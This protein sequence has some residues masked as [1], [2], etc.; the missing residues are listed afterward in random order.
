MPVP[1]RPAAIALAA[2]LAI[3]GCTKSPAV[4]VTNVQAPSFAAMQAAATLPAPTGPMTI[5]AAAQRAVQW[6]PAVR[7]AV[8]QLGQKVAG[9]E[10]ARA[11]YG[12]KFSWDFGS[13]YS[14]GSAFG[15][16]TISLTGSQTL[17]DFGK[18]DGRVRVATA[19][20]DQGHANI[21][22][23]VDKL[24]HETSTAVLEV[25]RNRKLLEIANDRIVQTES[26]L[27]LVRSRTDAG[28]STQSDA[29]QAEARLEAAH[30]AALEV[31]TELKRWESVALSL[32]AMNPP[33]RVASTTPA[34]LNGAC[35]ASV[36]DVKQ[37]PAVLEAEAR[38][39]IATAQLDLL[40]AEALPSLELRGSLGGS[41]SSLSRGEPD[42]RI[43][44][45]FGGSFYDGGASAARMEA[46]QYAAEAS[47]AAV[48]LAQIEA[49]RGVTEANSQ[50]S[51]LKRLQGA[52]GKNLTALDETRKLYRSQYAELGTR[53]LLDLLNAEDEYHLSRINEASVG[54]DL[55]RR[56]LDCIYNAGKM[57]DVLRLNGKTVQG[58]VL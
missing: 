9:V 49:Q 53:T 31:E 16:P 57:R 32:T 56:N 46:A 14:G 20:T 27:E 55:Q 48:A 45:T 8:A 39:S 54:F 51:S 6:H 33:L 50:L 17:Y 11:G 38:Q 22:L 36:V 19:G 41:F 13:D 21:L 3:A 34:W 29:L 47:K 15:A 42:Y 25:Q 58:V 26:V 52:L 18:V 23:A 28:A 7:E 30:A 24:A 4:R 40:K 44:I 37:A 43:G 10:E 12:P 1:Y 35:P 2:A 5:E